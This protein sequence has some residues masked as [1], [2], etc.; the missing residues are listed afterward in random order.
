MEVAKVLLA[1]AALLAGTKDAAAGEGATDLA[2][3]GAG[4]LVGGHVEVDAPVVAVAVAAG[5]GC[6]GRRTIT[7]ASDGSAG[8]ACLL[9]AAGGE[10]DLVV[11]DVGV[12]GA[13]EVALALTVTHEDDPLRQTTPRW[14]IVFYAA[15]TIELN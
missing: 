12:G 14:P 15:H 13:V 10:R 8:V 3:G 4:A 6:G 5:C 2:E 11:G 9:E 1:D 7:D